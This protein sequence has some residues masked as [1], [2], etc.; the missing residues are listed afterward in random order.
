MKMTPIVTLYMFFF[1]F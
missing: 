1:F